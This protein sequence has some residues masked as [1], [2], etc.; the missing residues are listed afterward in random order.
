[1]RGKKTRYTGLVILSLFGVSAPWI[2]AFAACATPYGVSGS[3]D[4]DAATKTRT[5]CDGTSWKILEEV[6]Y[7]D[8]AARR[9]LQIA[10]DTGNCTPAKK[11]RLR[12]SDITGWNYCDGENW[13]PFE[14]AAGSSR[15]YLV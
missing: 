9:R 5:I 8:A 1:M 2:P 10:D 6:D 13:L 11:G 15:G 7:A 3:M 14:S 4:Y 12:F